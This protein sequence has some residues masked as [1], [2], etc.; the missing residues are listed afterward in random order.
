MARGK[1][2]KAEQAF[3]NNAPSV[4]ATLN[5]M[6][7]D[8]YVLMMKTQACHWCARGSN[9]IGLH[10]LTE[11]QYAELFTAIDDVAERVRA[12][13]GQPPLSLAQMLDHASLKEAGSISDTDAAFLMLANDHETL[14]RAAQEGAEQ[15]EELEDPA[16]HDLLVARSASHDKAA[17]LL[18]SHLV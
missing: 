14:A 10:K 2:Q 8:T 9:F 16:T 11:A 4:A 7:G 13:G 6:L 5:A 15:A 3:R 18:R 1:G 17:W 12:I